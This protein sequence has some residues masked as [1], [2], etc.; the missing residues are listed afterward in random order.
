M[1]GLRLTSQW[2]I[3]SYRTSSLT[4][5][6]FLAG[7]GDICCCWYKIFVNK[8]MGG[9]DRLDQNISLYMISHRS[10]K[11][12][13]PVFRGF[14]DLSVSNAYQ[15][16][17]QQRRSEGERKLDLLNFGEV[18]LI[19][20]IDVFENQQQEICFPQRKS[21]RASVMRFGGAMDHWMGRGRRRGWAACQGTTLYFCGE[22]N[23]GLHHNSSQNI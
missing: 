22:C 21:C 2:L 5:D 14:L 16:Y 13:W 9:V 12:W 1:T 10:K 8:G 4:F 20:I 19:H 23:V 6:N 17:R 7:G 18:L 15:L 11:W 3:A